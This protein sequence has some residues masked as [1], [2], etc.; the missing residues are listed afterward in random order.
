MNLWL[1][2]LVTL[3]RAR[4]GK[5]RTLS[6]TSRVPFRVWPNDLDPNVHM[7]NG[8]YATLMD[9]G[10]IDLMGRAGKLAVL[11]RAEI[12]PVVTAQHILYRRALLPFERFTLSTRFIG[13]DEKFFYMEQLFTRDARGGELA[14]RGIVQATFVRRSGGRV[15]VEEIATLF[16]FGDVN[17]VPQEIANMFPAPPRAMMERGERVRSAA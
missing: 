14:A 5:R 3:L 6:D 11:Q 2:L 15:P 4:F 10:R 1:R 8:R 16:A 7:N 17:R 12:Y 13:G 9:L